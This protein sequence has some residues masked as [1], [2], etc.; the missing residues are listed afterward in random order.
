MNRSRLTMCCLACLAFIPLAM[1]A[2]PS[3]RGISGGE[4]VELFAAMD[5]GQLE[6]KLIPKDVKQATVIIKNKT[7]QPLRI[8]LPQ[9]FA[10]IPVL[11]QDD[12]G[13]NFGGGGGNNNNNNSNQ[14][15]SMG[16]GM[17]GMMGGMGGMGGFGGGGMFNVAPDRVG[18]VKVATICLEHGKN[19]PSPRVAYELRRISDFT[20]NPRIVEVCS[21]LGRGEIDQTSAQAAAWHLTD[22]L[23]WRELAQKVKIRHLD[24]RVEMY[25]NPAQ[26]QRALQIV[27]VAAKRSETDSKSDTSKKSPGE[28]SSSDI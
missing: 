1:A 16:G 2:K 8:R 17:G 12:F 26:I 20:D 5:T 7:D 14:N 23:S 4:T 19:D 13:G 10:G 21:M 28:V 15:Q 3:S 22:K 6:V 25:F 18:K 27:Q 24:G 11:A 9:A